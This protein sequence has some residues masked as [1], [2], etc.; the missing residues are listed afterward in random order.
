MPRSASR[1]SCEN[2]ELTIVDLLRCRCGLWEDLQHILVE[3]RQ[4][5]GR[6]IRVIIATTTYWTK[7][8]AGHAPQ[9]ERMFSTAEPFGL[10]LDEVQT[11]GWEEVVAALWRAAWTLFAGDKRQA[12]QPTLPQ[13]VGGPIH[14]ESSLALPPASAFTPLRAHPGPSFLMPTALLFV[15]PPL[16]PPHGVWI[17]WLGLR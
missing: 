13:D 11:F 5:A 1:M 9:F 16:P 17:V 7:V 10:L 3:E 4:A 2:A 15:T 6:N 8:Q 14:F 12:P